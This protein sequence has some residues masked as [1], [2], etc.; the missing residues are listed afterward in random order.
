MLPGKEAGEQPAFGGQWDE[1]C[2]N[3]M[4]E[5]VNE[6]LQDPST[7]VMAAI[8]VI[9]LVVVIVLHRAR[10]RREFIYEVSARDQ[11]L[12]E[13]DARVA[14]PEYIMRTG[15]GMIKRYPYETSYLSAA[16]AQRRF[17]SS[18][19][20]ILVE[21]EMR[22]E[23]FFTDI[24][25]PIEVG[26]D[27][28]CAITVSDDK[29]APR[30]FVM[31]QKDGRIEVRNLDPHRRMVIERGDAYHRVSDRAVVLEE[32]DVIH[33]GESRISISFGQ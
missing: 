27:S 21:T 6:V 23:R 2:M 12:A 26:R 9:M 1:K 30:Q 18:F 10:K 33:A 28:A 11:R 16:V 32:G 5:Y 25:T 3:S 4:R 22:R 8:L 20:G 19:I 7:W 31:E 15:P 29:L 13:L 24:S 17:E 14:N